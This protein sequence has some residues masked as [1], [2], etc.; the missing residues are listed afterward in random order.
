M[1]SLRRRNFNANRTRV[2]RYLDA[3]DKLRSELRV[4]LDAQSLELVKRRVAQIAS[5]IRQRHF[6]SGPTGRDGE[7]RCS[8][9]DFIGFCG[10]KE[11]ALSRAADS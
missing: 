1:P 5:K 11:R 7:H 4:P 2:V 9:C 10:V 6:M 8:T 3:E